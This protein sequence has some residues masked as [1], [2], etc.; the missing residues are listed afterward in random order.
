LQK[1]LCC[2]VKSKFI[3]ELG[4]HQIQTDPVRLLDTLSWGQPSTPSPS[5][6][7]PQAQHH[8]SCVAVSSTQ[9]CP[10]RPALAR[11]ER[12]QRKAAEPTL[13]ARR[14]VGIYW[15]CSITEDS[16]VQ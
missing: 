3:H 16:A 1:H 14:S 13:G 6:Q 15:V 11:M 10:A 4:S 12:G 8:L 5:S 9:R 7:D 2:K